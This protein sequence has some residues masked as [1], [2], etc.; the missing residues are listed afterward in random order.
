MTREQDDKMN[1]SETDPR[2]DDFTES[3]EARFHKRA[4]ARTRPD[5]KVDHRRVG[6]SHA[7]DGG[8]HEH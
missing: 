7:D 5:G 3:I 2:E 6:R 8:E 1:T 4:K